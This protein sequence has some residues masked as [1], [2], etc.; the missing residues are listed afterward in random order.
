MIWKNVKIPERDQYSFECRWSL[1]VFFLS[2]ILWII[3]LRSINDSLISPRA[4]RRWKEKS[5]A[6]A[7]HGE[8]ISAKVWLR[9]TRLTKLF[10]LEIIDQS[11][12][13]ISGCSGCERHHRLGGARADSR[14]TGGCPGDD[15]AS[16]SSSSAVG[17]RAGSSRLCLLRFC[18]DSP[19][20]SSASPSSS[21]SSSRGATAAAVTALSSTTGSLSL[22][23]Y[24]REYHVWPLSKG[25]LAPELCEIAFPRRTLE[26]RFQ[27]C[28]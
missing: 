12:W 19:P 23:R 26:T 11:R 20:S 2:H 8:Q 13:P 28:R 4:S 27:Q 10:P 17:A 1:K 21:P 22:S 9:L 14:R 25:E 3:H 15:I 6:V 18:L 7:T 24:T 16:S 5:A